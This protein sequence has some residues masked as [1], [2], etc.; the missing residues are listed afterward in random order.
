MNRITV[1]AVAAL[2][3]FSGTA[4]AAEETNPAQ[5][6]IVS[7][8]HTIRNFQNDPNLTS[9][10]DNV[11]KAKAV[12]VIPTVIRAG[13]I[14]GGSGGTGALL[15]RNEKTDRWSYPAFFSMGSGSIGF[16]A[17][18]EKAEMVLLIMSQKGVDS[19][20]S[21]N[22]KL[23]VDASVAT[24]PVGIGKTAQTADILAYSRAQGLYG[25]ISVDGAV[26]KP[27]SGLDQIYYQK[28]VNTADIVVKNAVSNPQAN[29]LRQSLDQ[30]G[31]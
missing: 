28:P 25:G 12:L 4:L 26:V 15:V 16:Q 9:F 30:L 1:L 6:V 20:L 24:G 14:F 17:G 27:R 23:G 29:P 19:L 8:E 13:F 31:H 5:Q 11:K 2:F 21:T 22:F 18:V 10:R 3:I 7:A